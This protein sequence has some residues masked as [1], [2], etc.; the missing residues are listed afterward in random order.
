M[1]DNAR[2]PLV[3]K[4]LN[5][6]FYF[7]FNITPSPFTFKNN[8]YFQQNKDSFCWAVWTLTPSQPVY[9]NDKKKIY[10]LYV[11]KHHIPYPKIK[12]KTR[13]CYKK[14]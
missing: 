10:E 3:I 8:H 9:C 1:L 5:A 14:V 6:N 13:I 11:Y 7:N 2:S 12:I 4:Y